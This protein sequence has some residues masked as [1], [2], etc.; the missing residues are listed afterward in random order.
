[1]QVT[2]TATIKYDT[3]VS[4]LR[5]VLSQVPANA[6]VAVKSYVGD[7]PGESSYSTLTFTWELGTTENLTGPNWF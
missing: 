1:M 3:T 2:A 5:E 4:E 6:K 7:R